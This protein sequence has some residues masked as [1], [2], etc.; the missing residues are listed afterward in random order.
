MHR[1]RREGGLTSS[2]HHKLRRGSTPP[3]PLTQHDGLVGVQR[4]EGKREGERERERVRERKGVREGR[5]GGKEEGREGGRE[6][7]VGG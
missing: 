2:L 7:G 6:G 5:E 3:M 1:R 4:R